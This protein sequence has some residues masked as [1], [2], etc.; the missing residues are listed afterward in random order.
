ML[1]LARLRGAFLL[2]AG[3]FKPRKDGPLI[4]DGLSTAERVESWAGS[5]IASVAVGDAA[6]ETGCASTGPGAGD[7]N[8]DAPHMPQ[9][10][11][12]SGFSLPQRAQR[13]DSLLRV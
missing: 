3:S 13:T 2:G 5:A 12:W 7:D 6:T 10:R 4:E 11:F 9:K 1:R 8:S